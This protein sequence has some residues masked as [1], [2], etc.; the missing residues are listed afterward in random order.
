MDAHLSNLPYVVV[1]L[2]D[3]LFAFSSRFVKSIVAMP[4]VVPIPQM[5]DYFRGVLN[6][7]GQVIPLLDLRVRFGYQPLGDEAKELCDTLRLRQQDHE[8]WIAELK[9]SVEERRK[10]KLATDP[11]KCAFGRWF[12]SY[13][14]Q[15]IDLMT[16]L[17]RFDKP[18]QAIHAVAGKVKMLEDQGDFDQCLAVIEETKN[19]ELAQMIKLF[20]STCNY[21]D[22]ELKE[23]VLVL[24]RR[25]GGM[26]AVAIDHVTT[27]EQLEEKSFEELSEMIYTEA[28]KEPSI[29]GFGIQESSGQY[30][31]IIDP[32][33]LL[34]AAQFR[35]SLAVAGEKSAKVVAETAKV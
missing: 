14:S 8:N 10:F 3:T 19:R 6:L 32:D 33:M 17:K 28:E 15:N 7:R 34:E 20:D 25:D 24:E 29:C 21:M 35:K 11:H 30:V 23:I 31:Q 18:H 13:Q 27:V 4:K 9:S 12:D 16:L 5:P 1:N 2:R 22:H 26:Y